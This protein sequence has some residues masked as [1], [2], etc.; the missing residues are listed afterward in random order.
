MRCARTRLRSSGSFG[1][2]APGAADPYAV[3]LADRLWAVVAGG[4]RL[5]L[6]LTTYKSRLKLATQMSDEKMGLTWGQLGSYNWAV[7]SGGN[8]LDWPLSV[9]FPLDEYYESPDEALRDLQALSDRHDTLRARL[10]VDDMASVAHIDAESL[11]SQ[12]VRGVGSLISPVIID[13]TAD[14]VPIA[15]SLLLDLVREEFVRRGDCLLPILI[16]YRDGWAPAALVSHTLTDGRGVQILIEDLESIR[17]GTGARRAV[18]LREVLELEASPS[19]L[20]LAA[21]C[22]RYVAER[23]EEALPRNLS[24]GI[25]REIPV[26]AEIKS[27][28]FSAEMERLSTV[29]RTSRPMIAGTVFAILLSFELQSEQV[30][31]RSMLRQDSPFRASCSVAADTAL[32]YI[33]VRVNPELSF[34]ELVSRERR[35]FLNGYR[36]ARYSP[37]ALQELLYRTAERRGLFRV[38][39]IPVLNYLSWTNKSSS[40]AGPEARF[41]RKVSARV[42]HEVDLGGLDTL[43]GFEVSEMDGVDSIRMFGCHWQTFEDSL[44][45]LQTIESFVH[46]ASTDPERPVKDLFAAAKWRGDAP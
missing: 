42:A 40:S 21:D 5:D 39:G 25:P 36:R 33:A 15:N 17:L 23:L 31:L 45:V 7:R 12:T 24:I 37:I 26:A 4:A 35:S 3:A 16:A 14:E 38:N 9:V 22:L 10:E 1:Y 27:S 29:L 41:R 11:P 30:L 44:D 8:A 18:E 43:G 13:R 2:L 46:L 32:A 19:H 28:R 20:A 6:P 34:R